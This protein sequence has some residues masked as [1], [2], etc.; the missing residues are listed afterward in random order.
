VLVVEAGPFDG[1]EDG[2]LVPG[3]YNPSPYFWFNTISA[4][5]AGL[6]NQVFFVIMGKVVGGGSTINAMFLHRPA[7]EEMAS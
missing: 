5:I 2:I 1:Q 4:P 3:D 6:L 7:A